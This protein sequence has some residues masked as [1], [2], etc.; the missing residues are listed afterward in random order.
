MTRRCRCCGASLAGRR[1]QA[2]YCSAGCR[3]RGHRS[4]IDGVQTVSSAHPGNPAGAPPET[5]SGASSEAETLCYAPQRGDH[6][7][8]ETAE[9]IVERVRESAPPGVLVA[10][11]I[12]DTGA[13]CPVPARWLAP[14]KR[15]LGASFTESPWTLSDP[16]LPP[17][18]DDWDVDDPGPR[19]GSTRGSGS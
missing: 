3:L 10:E 19:R 7:R 4:R 11:I 16:G 13:R 8:L 18:P 9:G 5:V 1:P 15:G 6:V 17:L 2:Q 12:W 14:A